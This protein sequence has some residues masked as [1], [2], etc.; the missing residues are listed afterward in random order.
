MLAQ[1]GWAI[2]IVLIGLAVVIFPDGTLV[3]PRLIVLRLSTPANP[4][5]IR[6][7]IVMNTFR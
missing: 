5:A 1:P 4:R 6:K 2:A 7:R 3:S